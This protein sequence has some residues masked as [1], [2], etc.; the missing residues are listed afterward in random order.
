MSLSIREKYIAP[1]SFYK[2]VF[3]IAV[4]IA[5]Q[6]ILNQAASFVDTI[7]VSRIG[8][9]GAV[10]IAAQLDNLTNNVGFG[11]NSGGQMYAAQFYG[12]KDEKSLKKIFGFQLALNLLN[13][14]IF[15]LIAF[16]FGKS[17]L[18][19][20]G[21]KN[22]EL[23]EIGWKYLS[24]SCFSY[25]AL[26]ITNTCSFMYRSIQRTKIPMYIGISVMFCNAF[27]NYCLI[28]GKFGL[29]EYGV[30]GAAIATVIATWFGAC[31]HILYAKISHQPFMGSIKEVFS[32]N[33]NFVKPILK[34]MFPLIVN[35]TLFGFGNTMYVKA[36]GL[37][38]K[39][40]LEIYKIGDTVGRF[41]YV[42][43]QGLNSATGVIIGEQLGKKNL[44]TA[45]QYGGY[46]VSVAIFLAITFCTMICVFASPMVS[47]FGLT[48]EMVYKGSVL[49][50]R[51][52][53]I[54]IAFRLFNVIIMSS[55]RSGGD[56]IFLMFLDC[57]IM[58]AVGLPLAFASY[59]ILHVNTVM[60]MF[61]IIQIEQLVRL[62]IG[63]KRYKEGKWIRNLT[64]TIKG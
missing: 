22:R 4:P 11:I 36:Y 24:I 6:Q 55:L 54:R 10:A 52:T 59:Y 17:V 42:C 58:W 41:F 19:F 18:S 2:K 60:Q 32:F 47:L 12:A 23:I 8:A 39:A 53:S 43:V 14:L 35:E 56:S 62:I 49:I 50:V 15:F 44:D 33:I 34:R 5:L 26:A 28:F 40:S 61:T 31:I 21:S 30:K 13:G 51:L 29:P 16:F 57:G 9:V 3:G 20:Y 64:D 38:G 27:L 1:K 7:M 63:F 46:L 25:F 45:K 48:N 37:L